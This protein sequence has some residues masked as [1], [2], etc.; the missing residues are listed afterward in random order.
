MMS[1]K[2]SVY[3][4]KE[5]TIS[6]LTTEPRFGSLGVKKMAHWEKMLAEQAWR[7]G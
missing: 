6:F 4:I 3:D 7:L 1:Q 2:P 5:Y